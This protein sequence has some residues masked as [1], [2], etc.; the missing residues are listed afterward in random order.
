MP[1]GGRGTGSV[2]NP[3]GPVRSA[4][5]SRLG[6][7]KPDAPAGKSGRRVE[8]ACPPSCTTWRRTR[9]SGRT[10]RRERSRRLRWNAFAGWRRSIA[11]SSGTTTRPAP[12]DPAGQDRPTNPADG[13]K[14][15]AAFQ[16]LDIRRRR[17]SK[18]WTPRANG[19]P[20][21]GGR[22]RKNGIWDVPADGRARSVVEPLFISGP[23]AEPSD[24][25]HRIGIG[26]G[27]AR[28]ECGGSSQRAVGSEGSGHRR[29]NSQP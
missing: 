2:S 23:R 22:R 25:R 24:G 1:G 17:T 11:Q 28:Q 7:A 10:W 16:R 21:V 29:I 9:P 13:K 18:D 27:S 26:W 19:V 20:R 3:G 8:I 12:T 15:R 5:T 6:G 4:V 14:V